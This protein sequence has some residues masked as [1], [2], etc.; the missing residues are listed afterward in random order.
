MQHRRRT[1]PAARGRAASAALGVLLACAAVAAT[2]VAAAGGA[3]KDP[4]AAVVQV[5]RQQVGDAY[6][7][8]GNGP[9]AWDC[10]G[11]TSYLWRAVGGVRDIP[12]VS[13]D[14]QAWAVPIPA[15]QLLPGDL[16]F[17]GDPVSHVALYDGNGLVVDAS[18][19]SR[20]VVK[21]KIWP[22]AV[23][24]YGR[25]PRAGMP[26]VKPWTPPTPSPSPSARTASAGT[27][28]AQA[29]ASPSPSASPKPGVPQPAGSARPRPS[30]AAAPDGAALIAAPL[31]G[32]PAPDL[33]ALT[34]IAVRAIGNALS[35]R[36]SK[37]WTDVALVQG[38][39]RHA[40]G[41][42]LPMDRSRLVSTGA[43]VP[44]GAARIGDL[45]VYGEPAAQVGLYLGHGYMVYASPSLGRVVVRRVFASSTVRIVRLGVR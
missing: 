10:S 21:R 22:A 18:S 34:T 13:M 33:P 39:W 19:A 41:G 38:A 30:A 3:G 12:R 6:R 37:A 23:I 42:G 45:V 29:A 14:Q 26:A 16:V 44:V 20:G 5:A 11:L 4:A 24:R 2:A 27:T 8:G 15:D 36:G 17:W 25:V 40:G 1:G 28:A 9:D 35:V 32:L 43:A 31:R 7:W